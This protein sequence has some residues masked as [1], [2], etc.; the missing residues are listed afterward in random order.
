MVY[1]S[2]MELSAIMARLSTFNRDFMV[3]EA[4]NIYYLALYR[5]SVVTPGKVEEIVM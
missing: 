1:I 5:R 3:H 2:P 4:K